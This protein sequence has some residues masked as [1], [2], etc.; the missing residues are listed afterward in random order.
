M[1]AGDAERSLG[2]LPVTGRVLELEAVYDRLRGYC[3]S[4]MGAR[5]IGERRALVEAEAIEARHDEWEEAARVLRSRGGVGLAA[6]QPLGE[7]R[8]AAATPGRVLDGDELLAAAATARVAVDLARHLRLDAEEYPSL[9]ELG[10]RIP[11]FGPLVRQI[12]ELIDDEG[13]VRDDASPTL[14]RLRR[15]GQKLRSRLRER[16]ESLTRD[17]DLQ[18]ALRD[19]LVSERSGRM[20]VPVRSDRR[21]R[22]EG[23]VHDRSSSG[24]TLWVE[25]LEAVE[26]QNRLAEL[27]GEI[28][29]EIRRLL[30]EATAHVR[31]ASDRLKRAEEAIAT[32]DALQALARW[33]ADTEATRPL[34]A[35][36]GLLLRAGHH[37]LVEGDDFVPL[38]LELQPGVRALVITGPNT[39]GKTVALKTLGLLAILAQAGIPVPAAELRFRPWRWVHADIG[40]EQSL[41]ANLST[42]SAHLHHIG[43]FLEQQEEGGAL[44]LLDELGTG[45]DP[46]EGAALGI[47]LLERFLERGDWVVASTHHDA[48]KSFAHRQEGAL[49]A[50]M[51]FDPE[52]LAPTYRIRVGEPGRSN[53]LEIAS[54]LGFDAD[55]VERARGLLGAD[56]VHLDEVIRELERERKRAGELSERLE[57]RERE[58]EQARE[59]VERAERERAQRYEEIEREARQAVRE[60]A[61]EVRQE[62]SRK[63]RDLERAGDGEAGS[64]R[65][66]DDRRARWSG[67]AGQLEG[68]ARR[69]L[70]H[71]LERDR[72]EAPSKEE[73][74]EGAPPAELSKG[75]EVEVAPFGLVGTVLADTD[76]ERIE[77]DVEGKRMVVSRDQLRPRAGGG[78]KARPGRRSRRV[79]TH[80]EQRPSVPSELDLHGQTVEQALE[81]VDKYLDDAILADLDEVRLVHG[82][83]T[84]ALRDAIRAW[85]AKRPGIASF[86][87]ADPMHGGAGVTVV[88]L[89]E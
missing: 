23:I 26:D 57:R 38:D 47:A 71:K 6:A 8:A 68:R 60:A 76:E 9:A 56:A 70:T 37:P 85:L 19:P 14:T 48:L 52:S 63:L 17:E 44:V 46:Q 31:A 74:T 55:L 59:S 36:E 30:A 10:A 18:K 39:G 58:L 54:R 43:S 7:I 77:V 3:Q 34:L 62:G 86:A 27:D 1:G 83:G 67:E 45:T 16:L 49:N 42:F 65:A 79:R 80:V 21:D 28:R 72:P 25:P 22:I 88:S 87:P 64:E 2:L 51:E 5:R 12:E 4:P 15:R 66:R 73:E 69:E 53:A 41:E 75:M 50:A 29:E 40:D 13:E 33:A 61:E 20:V 11:D 24:Q 35:D 32:Y 78:R 84:G 82:I 89:K 81:K